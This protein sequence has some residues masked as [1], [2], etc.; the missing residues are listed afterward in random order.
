MCHTVGGAVIV[1]VLLG[2]PLRLRVGFAVRVLL[3]VVDGLR[4]RVLVSATVRDWE[5]LR[6]GVTASPSGWGSL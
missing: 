2:V 4:V 5:A 6:D 1:A 3:R